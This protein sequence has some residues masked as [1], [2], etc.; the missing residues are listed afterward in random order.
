MIPFNIP[1]V[2]GN[3][4][5]YI[6]EALNSRKLS[7]DGYFTK[8]CHEWIETKFSIEKA[9]LTTSCTHALEMSAILSD[10]QPGDEVIMPSFTFVSTANAFV[11]RG[12]KI[13]FIDIRPDTMNMN[14]LI[15]EQAI[16]PRTVGIVPVHYAGVACEMDM[17]MNIASKYNLKVIEDA[18]QGVMSQYK[19]KFLGQIGHLGCYSFHE[20][21]NYSCGEG[22]SLLIN[23]GQYTERAEV[24]REK[25]TNRSRFFRGQVDKYTWVD[26]GSSYLPSEI[27]AAF[28][29]AQLEAA[30]QIN[31]NRL[32]SWNLYYHLFESLALKEKVNLPIVPDNCKHNAHM[33]YIK[34]R[35][36]EQRT[37]LIKFLKSYEVA[38]VFHYVPLHTSEAGVRFGTFSGE[39]LFTTSESEKLIRLPMYYNLSESDINKIVDIVYTFFQNN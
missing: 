3:E 35:N 38:G 29:Y 20:T 2:I 31:E 22:G 8:K 15:I 6:S 17:I 10:I 28:L 24:I 9:L 36:L 21:K 11:L 32:K 23:D 19:G 1:A 7:G 33:F 13:V 30:E 26:I 12:A 5:I 39:D 25:G 34:T 14:E 27:N 4:A 16:T 18:A 37:E